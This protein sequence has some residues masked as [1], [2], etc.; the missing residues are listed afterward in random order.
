MQLIKM[1]VD[2]VIFVLYVVLVLLLVRYNRTLSFYFRH[3]FHRT[4]LLKNINIFPAV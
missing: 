1:D 3:T 2:N 4:V